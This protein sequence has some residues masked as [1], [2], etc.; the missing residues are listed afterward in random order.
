MDLLLSAESSAFCL[1]CMVSCAAGSYFLAKRCMMRC[2]HPATAVP[3]RRRAHEME[4]LEDLSLPLHDGLSG[5]SADTASNTRASR[6]PC[7][8]VEITWAFAATGSWAQEGPWLDVL[9]FFRCP[10]GLEQHRQRYSS[11]RECRILLIRFLGF[12]YFFAFLCIAFQGRA[13][14]G[15]NGLTPVSCHSD[16]C[17]MIT[18]MLGLDRTLELLGWTGVVFG[19]LQM[20]GVDSVL[21]SLALYA[22][23]LI[24]FQIARRANSF[25]HY[26][27]DFQVSS[28]LPVLLLLL[29]LL[30]L[31]SYPSSPRIPLLSLQSGGAG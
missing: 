7:K 13:L 20:F 30:P 2:S 4:D 23:Y 8:T 18:G 11:Q 29:F 25:F 3:Q 6:R 1:A 26:G 24:F 9:H 16:D 14:I 15:E 12:V 27:W 17:P 28:A 19:A 21:I 10:P 31:P 22:M 5:P